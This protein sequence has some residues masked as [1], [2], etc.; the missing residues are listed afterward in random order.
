MTYGVAIGWRKEIAGFVA[1]LPGLRFTEVVAESLPSRGPAP[2][3]LTALRERGVAVVPHGVRLSLGGTDPVDPA[4]VAHLAH[5]AS[6]VDA[7][8][9]S[10]HIAFVRAGGTEAGHLLPLP[11]SREAVATVVSNVRRTQDGLPVPIA[12]EPIAALVEW[13][14][15]ELTEAQFLTEILDRT[16]AP[17]LLDIANVYANARNRGEDPLA[18]LDALPLDRIAYVHVAGGAEHDGL[19][20]DTHT[21]PVPPAVL[22]LVTALCQ[23]K[24]PPALMLERDGHYPPAPV[25]TA[26]LDAIADAAGLP[27]ITP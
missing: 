8:M 20:H 2:P 1:D 26:E 3:A 17:L 19:Y 6:I 16:G 18:L 23:R 12:L 13:P 11:R 22:E 15:D 10:E 21:D 5:C 25:L 14:D 27:R 9:V 4:Q 24:V 7:P